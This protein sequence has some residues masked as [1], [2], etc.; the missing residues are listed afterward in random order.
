MLEINGEAVEGSRDL[1]RRVGAFSA[2]EEVRFRVLRD[3]R[4]RTL[5]VT[6]G[7]RPSE[8]DLNAMQNA[9]AAEA[10]ASYF[11]M[12]LV[13]M[14]DEDR[15]RYGI[16][17]GTSGLVVDALER[18]SEAAQ[19]GITSGDIVLEA[20]GASLADPDDFSRAVARAREDGRSAILLLVETRGGQRYVALQLDDNEE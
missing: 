5:R 13:P 4:E 18:G 10:E 1:T 9:G 16:D 11:G 15:E 6:L 7:D 8:D 2:G 14:S 19:K 12:Q 17:A 20:G 3:G